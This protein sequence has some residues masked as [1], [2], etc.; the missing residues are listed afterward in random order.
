[1]TILDTKN[2]SVSGRVET[3]TKDWYKSIELKHSFGQTI[4]CN[5]ENEHWIVC[6]NKV[7]GSRIFDYN[8]E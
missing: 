5:P 6:V 8:E 1:M 7:I 2:F 4:G 3:T